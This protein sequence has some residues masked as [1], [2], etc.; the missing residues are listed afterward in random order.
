MISPLYRKR[1]WLLPLVLILF[2]LEV[3]LF[4]FAAGLTYAGRSE[5]PDH[6]LT[7]TSGKLTWDSATD[8]DETT[9]TAEL[10][11]FSDSYQNVK[12]EDGSSVVAPG[13]ENV[14]IVRLKNDVS[15][16]VRY[17][18]VMYRIKEEDSLPVE[19]VLTDDSAF[20]D[21]ADYPLPDGI[22]ESPVVR[23]IT[24]RVD[25][26][27]IQE[28]DIAW[29][30]NYYESDQRDQTDTAL[31]NK[32]AFFEADEVTAGIY[33]VVEDSGGS[34]PPD[35]DPGDPNE[36]TEPGDPD[37]PTD[38]G[39]PGDPSDPNDPSDPGVPDNP[40]DPARYIPPP[41]DGDDSYIFPE[42]PKTGDSSQTRMY[43]VLMGVSGLLL[44]LLTLDR[45]KERK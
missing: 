27:Q 16:T 10:N 19:P 43:L 18:A 28:F 7:Y 24:G 5:S 4:P 41:P 13:T 26:G 35:P 17:V 33:I 6:V 21:T 14:G 32:A 15:H 44:L 9:G 30:C 39:D 2:L 8:I 11:L 12:S 36:P 42:V 22:A 38:P 3:I 23:A 31:G 20:S 25:G 45:R 34:N 40:E 37:N 29:N 1:Q